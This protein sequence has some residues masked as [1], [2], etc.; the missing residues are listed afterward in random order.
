MGILK[1]WAHTDSEKLYC[2]E[3][4][5]GEEQ[6]RSIASGLRSYY[7]ENEM[8]NRHVLVVCNLKKRNFLG[9]SSHGMILCACN[10]SIKEKE[11]ELIQPAL[12]SIIGERIVFDGY[13]KGKPESENR[14]SKKKILEAIL[15]NLK[16]NQNGTLM[17]KN[18]IGRTNSGHCFVSEVMANSK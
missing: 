12:G 6:P 18:S 14:V 11:V 13:E 4:D 7:S 3:I 10:S 9:F 2:E 1:V 8:Q 16:T 17:W 15:P 5:V